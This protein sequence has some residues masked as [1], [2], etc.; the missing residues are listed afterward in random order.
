MIFMPRFLTPEKG[1]ENGRQDGVDH[2]QQLL[3][4]LRLKCLGAGEG[5]RRII[6]WR[7]CERRL[8]NASLSLNSLALSVNRTAT[9][10]IMAIGRD[11]AIVMI[12]WALP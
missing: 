1:C 7:R 10:P 8:Q 6:G 12:S 3:V 5:Q 4:R 11:H 2:V 9:A